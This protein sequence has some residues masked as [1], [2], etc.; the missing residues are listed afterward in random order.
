MPN[1]P[2][3]L[4]PWLTCTDYLMH[5]LR[6][7]AGDTALEVIQQIW[8][9]SSDWDEHILHLDHDLVMHRDIVVSAQGT[10]CWFARTILPT[11]TYQANLAL[12]ERLQHEPLGNLIFENSAIQRSTMRYYPIDPTD[13][14]YTWIPERIDVQQKK[15]WMRLSKFAVH[16]TEFFYLAEILLPGLEA[17]C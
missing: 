10:P 9:P 8:C 16:G 5:K 3:N 2:P 11:T 14:E 1:P 7:I 6:A 4:L 17:Y 15:L 12:F 13:A